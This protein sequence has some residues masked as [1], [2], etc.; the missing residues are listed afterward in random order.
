MQLENE[1]RN[2]TSVLAGRVGTG[3]ATAPAAGR[4]LNF[5]DI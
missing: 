4:V 2:L 5:A 1:F 3:N